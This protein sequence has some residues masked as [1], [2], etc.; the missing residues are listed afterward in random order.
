MLNFHEKFLNY[1]IFYSETNK[2]RTIRNNFT[3][4]TSDYER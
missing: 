1:M 2:T 3:R 4:I